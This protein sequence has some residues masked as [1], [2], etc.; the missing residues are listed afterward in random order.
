MAELMARALAEEFGVRVEW[1]EERSADTWEN[2][3]FSAELLRKDGVRTVLLVSTAWHLPRAARC[4]RAHDLEVVPAP[5]GFRG[6][7]FENLLSLLPHWQALRDTGHALHEWLG[8]GY[9]ALRRG[10]G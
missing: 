6:A 9:Y 4:F 7:P 8:R 2:A 3:A 1:R 10:R 5:T